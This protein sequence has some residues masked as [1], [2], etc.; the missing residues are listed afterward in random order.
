MTWTLNEDTNGWFH[1]EN[2]AAPS[3]NRPLKDIGEASS[4]VSTVNTGGSYSLIASNQA[5]VAYLDTSVIAGKTYFYVCAA[6]DLFG[7]DSPYSNEAAATP[8]GGFKR[9]PTPALRV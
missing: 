1:L 6:R 4:M 3:G 9:R 2:P 5:A 7:S 8:A